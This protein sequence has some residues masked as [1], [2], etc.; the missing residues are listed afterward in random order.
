MTT[1]SNANAALIDGNLDDSL[2]KVFA[3][4]PFIRL[5]VVRQYSTILK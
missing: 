5:I 2:F 4:L 3:S 1:A